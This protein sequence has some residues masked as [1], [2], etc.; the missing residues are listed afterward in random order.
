MGFKKIELVDFNGKDVSSIKENPLIGDAVTNKGIFDKAAK[1]VIMP[2]FNELIDALM[3]N[4]AAGQIKS[5]AK[6]S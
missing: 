6:R 3:A 1:E 2:A 5:E 4:D